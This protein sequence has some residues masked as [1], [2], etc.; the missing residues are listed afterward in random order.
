MKLN[1]S[2]HTEYGSHRWVSYNI[3]NTAYTRKA[4]EAIVKKYYLA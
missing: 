1:T 3:G 4:F 2:A